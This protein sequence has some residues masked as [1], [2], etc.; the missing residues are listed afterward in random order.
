MRFVLGFLFLQ[1]CLGAS[2]KYHT[3]PFGIRDDL[4]IVEDLDDGT[5]LTSL[6]TD[7]FADDATL[8]EPAH[9]KLSFSNGK[10]TVKGSHSFVFMMRNREYQHP[11]NIF[12]IVETKEDKAVDDDLLMA[13]KMSM[14]TSSAHNNNQDDEIEMIKRISELEAE[15]P[16]RG[17][18]E[19][20]KQMSLTVDDIQLATIESLKLEE[21][22]PPKIHNI[23]VGSLAAHFHQQ[24]T[25]LEDTFAVQP[26]DFIIIVMKGAKRPN[27]HLQDLI[28]HINMINEPEDLHKLDEIYLDAEYHVIMM[29]VTDYTDVIPVE[30]GIGHDETA[31]HLPCGT[32]VDVANEAIKLRKGQTFAQ[33]KLNRSE[34]TLETS[35]Q[36]G[37]VILV[38]RNNRIFNHEDLYSRDIN[39]IP[40]IKSTIGH[41]L[42][43]VEIK[44][45][46]IVILIVP[47]Q[48][49]LGGKVAKPLCFWLKAAIELSKS[50]EFKKSAD[51]LFKDPTTK[52]NEAVYITRIRRI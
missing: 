10:C 7:E 26:D 18:L 19:Y 40:M 21:K 42:R 27:V 50:S 12:P 9:V 6:L 41:E 8:G 1:V 35:T 32:S 48:S 5:H 49:G 14:E 23:N 17:E 52:C 22:A 16:G 34:S 30:L 28:S 15:Y 4:V 25:E 51:D 20:A 3:T 38:I 33:I 36:K 13:M 43:T 11:M 2:A 31:M 45:G 39:S 24:Q 37:G 29:R 46:D 47:L 44:E